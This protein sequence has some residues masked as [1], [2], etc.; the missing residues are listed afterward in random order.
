VEVAAAFDDDEYDSD[1]YG[2]FDSDDEKALY[3][4]GIMNGRG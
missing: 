4:M 1:A 3:G 2:E